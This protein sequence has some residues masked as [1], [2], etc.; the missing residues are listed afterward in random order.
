MK[1]YDVICMGTGEIGRPLYELLNGVYKTLP[2][3]PVHYPDNEKEVAPC[4]FLHI[5]IPGNLDIAEEIKKIYFY[6]CPKYIIIHSTVVPGTIEKMQTVFEEPI[7]HAPVQGKHAGNQM[8]KDMLRYPKYLGFPHTVSDAEIK[9]VVEHFER[10]GFYMVK[11][12]MGTRNVEWQKVLATSLFGWQIAWAQEVERICDK[13]GLDFD[14]VTDIYNYIE[15]IIPP[16]YSGVIG[17]HCVMPNIE[18]INRIYNSPAFDFI[19]RSN[20][21]KEKRDES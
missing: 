6:A 10:A 5:C 19:K 11:P 17:G 13:F 12:I 8:K 16:H 21:L 15:D 14:S 3:D 1:T 4:T 2:L 9:E 20:D 18:L 7:I